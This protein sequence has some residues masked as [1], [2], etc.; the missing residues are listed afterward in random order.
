MGPRGTRQINTMGK[1]RTVT[2]GHM[3]TLVQKHIGS[4]SRGVR[5]TKPKW[6]RLRRLMTNKTGWNTARFEA[7]AASHVTAGTFAITADTATIS[8][9]QQ[10]HE[11]AM[12]AAG[13]VTATMGKAIRSV[14]NTVLKRAEHGRVSAAL[15][16]S[17]GENLKRESQKEIDAAAVVLAARGEIVIE[18]RVQ[19]MRNEGTTWADAA[20]QWAVA[21]GW[22]GQKEA[23]DILIKAKKAIHTAGEQVPTIIE[24]GSGW[25]GATEGLRRVFGRVVTLD[26]AQHPIGKGRRTHPD[27]LASFQRG[28]DKEGGV[29]RWAARMS[30]TTVQ[31]LA[32]VWASP[33]CTEESTCQ[34]FNK[35]T[36]WGKGVA[37]GKKRS[38]EATQAMQSVLEGIKQARALNPKF[39][40]VLENVAAA[41]RNKV[42]VKALGEP[43]IIPGCVYGRKSGKKYAVW[44]SPEAES[45]YNKT[46][47]HPAGPQSRCK[48]CQQRTPHEQAACP[49][50]GDTRGRVREQGQTVVAA[51]NRVPPAMAEHLGWCMMQAWMGTPDPGGWTNSAGT[52]A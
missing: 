5:I 52:E 40:Y 29:V 49:K 23:A 39:Q 21:A 33:A 14:R 51:A 26:K 50:K 13:G 27:I 32:A 6:T 10:R 2:E 24:L 34:G 20:I 36:P 31:E 45:L 28:R 35:G 9:E 48:A 1:P 8:T 22:M 19:T 42:I 12:I 18:A 43:T 3:L 41:A 7:W 4:T 38:K 30:R 46:K 44:M 37:A 47:I 15:L 11:A 17:M 16:L 25:N